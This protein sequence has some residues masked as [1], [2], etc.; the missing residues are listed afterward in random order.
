MREPDPAC[1]KSCETSFS[2]C[3]QQST[4][5]SMQCIASRNMC[6][7][8]CPDNTAL[9]SAIQGRQMSGV[10]EGIAA[11]PAQTRVDF[12]T[13]RAVGGERLVIA[14]EAV[15]LQGIEPWPVFALRNSVVLRALPPDQVQ[16]LITFLS[17]SANA[18][19]FGAPEFGGRFEGAVDP[20]TATASLL[21]R[22]RFNFTDSLRFGHAEPGTPNWEQETKDGKAKFKVDFKRV[23]E[24]AWSGRTV[25]PACPIA[26]IS[27]LKTQVRVLVVEQ[28]EHAMFNVFN[29]GDG[30]SN[31]GKR[32]GNLKTSDNVSSQQT[33]QVSDSTG[34]HPE[35]VTTT[36]IP[37]T[38]EFGHAIGIG[39][40][41]CPGGDDNCYGVTAEERRDIMGAGDQVQVI[42]RGG[43]V[44]HDDLEPFEKIAARWG[45]DVAS[46]AEAKCNTWSAK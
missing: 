15:A 19:W 46:A 38:H 16:T 23:V 28:N 45:R 36:Q 30:R 2:E 5:G 24:Q 20:T 42:V 33:H 12:A 34:K 9:L 10:L 6:L 8:S 3:T 31:M 35:Q 13:G 17:G 14:M 1:L 37:S 21:F 29:D 25:T 7:A 43:K 40:P 44:V 41:H 32:E 4:D 11:L 26:G 18:R 39:H 27:A 22:V